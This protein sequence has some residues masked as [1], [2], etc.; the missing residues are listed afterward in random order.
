MDDLQT[1]RDTRVV[2]HTHK[3]PLELEPG[4]TFLLGLCVDISREWKLENEQNRM[5][6]ALN[7]FVRNEQMLNR[8]LK[9]ITVENDFET[10]VN[11]I[12][13]RRTAASSSVIPT[14]T[15]WGTTALSGCARGSHL[16]SGICGI[17]KWNACKNCIA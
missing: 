8:C 5:I 6:D 16:R 12:L 2:Y 14:M 9:T 1:V 13:K 10:A 4:K 17:S 15:V 3:I 11:E 7:D